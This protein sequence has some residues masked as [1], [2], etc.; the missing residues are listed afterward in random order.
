MN[1]RSSWLHILVLWSEMISLCKELRIIYNILACNPIGENQIIFRELVL[2]NSL[3]QRTGSNNWFTSLF[4]ESHSDVYAIIIKHW[5][6][7]WN[8][9]VLQV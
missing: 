7:M 1:A 3:F 9:D 8:V 2:S 4:T 5:L 6:M